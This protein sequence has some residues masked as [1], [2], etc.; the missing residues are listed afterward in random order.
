MAGRAGKR[1]EYEYEY[2]YEYEVRKASGG[3][4]RA[5][6]V[7]RHL[8]RASLPSTPNTI[9]WARALLRGEMLAWRK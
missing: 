6:P 8:R 4:G 7:H 9:P 2:E 5:P 3:W 1:I